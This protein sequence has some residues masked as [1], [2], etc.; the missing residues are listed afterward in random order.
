MLKSQI[1][2][3]GPKKIAAFKEKVY[4]NYL[5]ANVESFLALSLGDEQA[6]LFVKHAMTDFQ[7]MKSEILQHAD[8]SGNIELSI[9]TAIDYAVAKTVEDNRKSF[10]D[11]L[12]KSYVEKDLINQLDKGLGRYKDLFFQ[13]INSAYYLQQERIL[14]DLALDKD[15]SKKIALE[16]DI[17]H[18]QLLE[19][20]KV[21]HHDFID[22]NL[23][24][25]NL[26]HRISKEKTLEQTPE[27]L[28]TLGELELLL[29]SIEASK[30]DSSNPSKNLKQAKIELSL[31]LYNSHLH[32]IKAKF[33]EQLG[34]YTELFFKKVQHVYEKNKSSIIQKTMGA[35][36][37]DECII[38]AL[39]ALTV[40][41]ER[42]AHALKAAF[43]ELNAFSGELN[44]LLVQ[45]EANPDNNPC[46]TK[47]IELLQKLKAFIHE[48]P[49]LQ[50]IDSSWVN[51]KHKKA[52]GRLDLIQ[53]YDA[54]LQ[55][56]ELLN[57][58]KVNITNEESDPKAKESKI[59]MVIE[60]QQG[61]YDENIEVTARLNTVIGKLTQH[62]QANLLSVAGNDLIAET[63]KNYFFQ[64]QLRKEKE[65]LNSV[66]GPFTERFMT[67]M[68]EELLLHKMEIKA[69]ITVG[70]TSDKV[71]AIFAP[72]LLKLL[73]NHKE[74]YDL[75]SRLNTR[76]NHLDKLIAQEIGKWNLEE[77]AALKE[78]P[79]H[80]EKLAFLTR[81]RNGLS[82]AALAN[83]SV[84]ILRNKLRAVEKVN[85]SARPYQ[86]LTELYTSLHSMQACV[87]KTPESPL[88]DQ[89]LAEL[90][91]LKKIISNNEPTGTRL[92]AICEQSKTSRKILAQSADGFFMNLLKTF[93]ALI[94]K[95]LRKEPS[96]EEK[97]AIKYQSNLSLFKEKID[98]IKNENN[99][100]K[101]NILSKRL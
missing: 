45:E 14:T 83:E 56:N 13:N 42:Q 1:E 12:F 8:I 53:E 10:K 9:A 54:L 39:A 69:E 6:A 89:K 65:K 80:N 60:L 34:D 87:A 44:K 72:Y 95:I 47:K 75:C 62:S 90:E 30:I 96:L 52:L 63:F 79:C 35:E 81:M 71:E 41:I 27:R 33:N 20:N 26:T 77:G 11:L 98:D 23:F 92:Q 85:V 61:L 43:I 37:I 55:I 57:L 101:N 74:L 50:N 100:Q 66:L 84:D 19:Q 93:L 48:V 49:E 78:N 51:N 29:H 82:E 38:S 31:I 94:N 99:S 7:G 4:D 68:N 18:A 36:Q 17:V 21:L 76:L 70:M 16:L 73:A 59:K 2:V 3:I 24:A 86:Q 46:R 88:K 64:A 5:K 40:D 67:V 97:I 22:L 25:E 32:T 15:L 28:E 91:L 58:L